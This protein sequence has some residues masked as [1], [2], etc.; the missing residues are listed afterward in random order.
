VGISRGM[1]CKEVWPRSKGDLIGILVGVESALTGRRPL[2]EG[3][4]GEV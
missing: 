1:R 3:S 2:V 4:S